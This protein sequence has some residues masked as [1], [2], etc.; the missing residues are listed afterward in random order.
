MAAT[1]H[2]IQFPMAKINAR[3]NAD[4]SLLDRRTYARSFRDNHFTGFAFALAFERKI[5][6]GQMQEDA[7]IDIAIDGAD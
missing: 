3:K 4:R 1:D 6:A 2:A 7:V 5:F